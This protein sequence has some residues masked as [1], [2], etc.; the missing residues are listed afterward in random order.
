MNEINN[1]ELPSKTK[2]NR[3]YYQQHKQKIKDL[4]LKGRLENKEQ[5][6]Q[7][8]REYYLKRKLKL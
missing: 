8:Q 1:E 4:V 3:E 2:Y 6:K 5:Y 7:Y